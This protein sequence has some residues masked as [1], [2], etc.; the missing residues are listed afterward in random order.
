MRVSEIDSNDCCGCSL[1]AD[2]CPV[3]AITMKQD[4]EGFLYPYIDSGKC[5]NCSIC[6]KGCQMKLVNKHIN[7]QYYYIGRIKSIDS[8]KRSAS[9]GLF[10]AISDFIL[11]NKGVVFGAVYNDDFVVTHARANTESDRD[12]MRDS[13]YV[14]SSIIDSFND[15]HSLLARGSTVLF[16]GTPCQ[17]A[18]VKTYMNYKRIDCKNLFL[19]DIICHGVG[20]PLVW[21]YYLNFIQE[22]YQLGSIISIRT[23]NKQ[24]GTGYNMT[25]EGNRY[26]HM[27]GIEDPYICLFSKNL[28]LRPS[29]Y[30]CPFKSFQR[31]GDISIGDYQRIKE[32]PKFNDGGGLSSII[33][34]SFKGRSLFEAIQP[35]V[36]YCESDIEHISQVNLCNQL[37][38]PNG[39]SRFFSL[40][41]KGDFNKA[42]AQ[43]TEEGFLNRFF[44][45]LKR[46][47]RN[48]CFNNMLI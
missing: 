20:S 5:I 11:N 2:L 1:C 13:K 15:I 42:L 7:H 23:R 36:D 47:L 48:H 25:I 41:N 9:G 19:V 30:K 37:S 21:E 35:Y 34:N 14:Q 6:Y 3:S 39:R 38:I 27:R 10:T 32:I 43:F 12:K 33:I 45:M 26:Y 40:I 17:C 4:K 16:T 8:L 28:V 46:Y 44:G 31:V 29:C 22:K 24:F 18:A